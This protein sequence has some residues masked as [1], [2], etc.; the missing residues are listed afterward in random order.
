[1]SCTTIKDVKLRRIREL[2][3]FPA[4]NQSEHMKL[5]GAHPKAVG[6]SDEIR[7]LD[8]RDS[9][10]TFTYHGGAPKTFSIETAARY[11]LGKP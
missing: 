7:N 4:K 11:Y 3:A 8:S 1:M 5:C 10:L 2:G 6:A 9:V